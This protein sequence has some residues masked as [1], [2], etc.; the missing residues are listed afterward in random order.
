MLE[1]WKKKRILCMYVCMYVC[2]YICM[3]VCIYVY[4]YVYVCV[5]VYSYILFAWLLIYFKC[6]VLLK[7]HYLYSNFVVTPQYLQEHHFQKQ[8]PS[9]GSSRSLEQYSALIVV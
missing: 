5:C 3:Y 7:Y 9:S 2:M 4:M 6:G 1:K 8:K